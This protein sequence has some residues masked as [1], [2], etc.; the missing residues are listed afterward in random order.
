MKTKIGPE[1]YFKSAEA[2]Q[3]RFHLAG[4]LD[5]VGELGH[6][7]KHFSLAWRMRQGK[8]ECIEPRNSI[9]LM[10]AFSR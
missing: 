10:R 4:F 2:Y 6:Y 3:H 8:E 1:F 9:V 5:T 7:T